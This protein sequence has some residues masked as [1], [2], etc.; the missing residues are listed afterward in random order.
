MDRHENRRSIFPVLLNW[1]WWSPILLLP[2]SAV[3]LDTWL[4]TEAI[5]RDYRV[6]EMTARIAEAQAQIDDLRVRE[7]ELRTIRR[8]D[9]E[10]PN[11]GLKQPEPEQIRTIY[12]TGTDVEDPDVVAFLAQE[13]GPA[14]A[15]ETNQGAPT[16][17][18][19]GN[20]PCYDPRM[21]PMSFRAAIAHLWRNIANDLH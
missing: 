5:Q 11:L 6:N 20:G 8:I 12:Y 3:F 9:H 15:E 16:A 1:V 2:F 18:E 4:S 10:A 21:E 13:P 17:P 7:A 14:T 19:Q